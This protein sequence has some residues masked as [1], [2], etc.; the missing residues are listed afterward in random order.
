[1]LVS[2][3][4]TD[5]LKRLLLTF[6]VYC[7]TASAVAQ[8]IPTTIQRVNLLFAGDIMQHE[9]QLKAARTEEGTYS[10]TDN[11]RYIRSTISAADI[12]V[13]NLET[14][15]GK[16]NFSGYPSFC[17]PDSFLYAA[18]NAGF[19][20][21]L[22]A[23]NHCLDKGKATALYTLDL[24]DS[25]GIAHCGVYRDRHDRREHY[26][27]IIEKNGVRIALL[28]YTYGTNGRD[29]PSPMIVNLIDKSTIAQDITEAKCLNAD[30][31]IAC[32]HWG[33]E[34]VSL[35]PQRIKELSNWLIEQGVD[36]II[37]NHPHVIQPMEL[38]F[39]EKKCKKNAVVYS[40]GNLLSNMSLR[41]TDGGVMASMELT[42]IL[43]Y[44][45]VSSL[46]YILTWIAPKDSY[47]KRDFTIYPAATTN[48]AGNSQA[49]QKLQLF[50]DDSRT[51][52]KEHNKGDI[53]EIVTDSVT[54][55]P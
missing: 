28:N 33:D 44:T 19:D 39:D 36:H 29:V 7:V 14:P 52:M 15:I 21:L 18:V 40:T 55:I 17:A 30:V 37:G 1:M 24:M 16:S 53:I 13:G 9:A 43:N 31:I 49:R 5:N 27:L 20:V 54:F 47:G 12:A 10:Y 26:P 8:Y 50:L 48:V 38:R 34:Y 23:N 51:L 46:G 42:K 4:S 32:M 2:V 25:L 45:R 22:F 3:K 6:I 35:P 11:W 41:R